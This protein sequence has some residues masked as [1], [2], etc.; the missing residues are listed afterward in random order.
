MIQKPRLR[1]LPANAHWWRLRV[2]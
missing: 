2:K 1:W